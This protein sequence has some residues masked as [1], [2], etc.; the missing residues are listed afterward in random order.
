MFVG[1]CIRLDTSTQVRIHVLPSRMPM[2]WAW[3]IPNP[4]PIV[5]L[6]NRPYARDSGVPAVYLPS[7]PHSMLLSTSHLYSKLAST[8]VVSSVCA[9][10]QRG[11]SWLLLLLQISV[12]F[13]DCVH[14]SAAPPAC[15]RCLLYALVSTSCHR[16]SGKSLFSTTLWGICSHE[17]PPFTRHHL[18]VVA[19]HNF[20]D[21]QRLLVD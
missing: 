9:R 2:H 7:Y 16:R 14:R 15:M 19:M 3:N 6:R 12:A 4:D 1:R 5:D 10:F 11:K 18:T 21:C 13:S 17:M 8:N 20:V